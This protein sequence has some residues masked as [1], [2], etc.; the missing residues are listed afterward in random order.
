MGAAPTWPISFANARPDAEKQKALWSLL[1]TL[2]RVPIEGRK[3]KPQG[4]ICLLCL[5]GSA[6]D[7]HKYAWV[8]KKHQTPQGLGHVLLQR[9]QR[10]HP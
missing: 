10:G 4:F 8:S 6:L 9:H 1:S 7:K 5:S 3:Q 2:T